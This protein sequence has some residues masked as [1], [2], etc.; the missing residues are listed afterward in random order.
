MKIFFL[1]FGA[2]MGVV[3][4]GFWFWSAF[5][6]VTWE[7][8]IARRKR[9]AAKS[10]KTPN[11]GGVALDGNDLSATIKL[12]STLNAAAAA[13]SGLAILAQTASSL[14]Q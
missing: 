12:Q 13:L 9:V 6:R 11:L 1:I 14:M 2:A 4:A 8:S 7:R 5:A 3:S 10:G